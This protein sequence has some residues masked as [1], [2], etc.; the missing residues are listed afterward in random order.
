MSPATKSPGGDSSRH[1]LHGGARFRALAR[2]ATTRPP[3]G[4]VIA[5]H[6]AQLS[7]C[8]DFPTYII[9]EIS[10]RRPMAGET[11]KGAS[12]ETPFHPYRRNA[13]RRACPGQPPP[14]MRRK[15]RGAGSD[16]RLSDRLEMGGHV[17]PIDPEPLSAIS[18]SDLRAASTV[19]KGLACVDF[20]AT[21]KPL[22]PEELE[23]LGLGQFPIVF[24]GVV[25]DRQ[26]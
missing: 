3:R 21:D 9:V 11:I 2:G 10:A 13:R 26:C 4:G 5:R 12:R 14:L 7:T 8:R 23:R 20:G 15:V 25:P 6:D 22:K 17:S 16:P 19:I 1:G 18:R 24:G